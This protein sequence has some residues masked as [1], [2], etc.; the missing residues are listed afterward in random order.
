M[1]HAAKQQGFTIIELVLAMAFISALLLAIAMTIIQIGTIY[2]RGMTLKEV[3]QTARS[4]TD[5]LNRGLAASDVASLAT[6]Y[7]PTPTGG[8][9]CLGQYSYIWNYA[10]SYGNSQRAQYVNA[11]RNE[12]GPI[13]FV[14]VP[15]TSR[16]YCQVQ[17]GSPQYLHIQNADTDSAVELLKAGD[18][19][20]SIHQ[21]TLRLATN[22][23]D[24]ATG[25]QLYNL[26][27]TIG[28][29][30]VSALTADQSACLP[31]NSPNSDFAYCNVQKFDLVVRAGNKVN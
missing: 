21:F 28:T 8:R 6:I 24:P 22:G 1:N 7:A 25:Q 31:P 15:D 26:S 19:A 12:T 14:R 4:M 18:R 23:A 30:N 10:A 3:N 16:K 29:G 17:T 9:L 2:N 27:F 13:R 5:E 20:L 11:A